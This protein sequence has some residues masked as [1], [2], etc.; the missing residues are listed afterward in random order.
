MGR[1]VKN[2]PMTRNATSAES[3]LLP[4]GPTSGRP[5][6]TDIGQM[7]FNVTDVALEYWDDVAWRTLPHTGLVSI[8]REQ[9]AGDAIE[10]DFTMSLTVALAT[11]ILVFVGGVFQN[12]T[13]SFTVNGTD[14]LVFTSPPPLSEVIVVMHGY[15]EIV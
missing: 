2:P 15:N 14:Q 11:D 4:G 10:T 13:V 6:V 7:R 1:L 9:F 12:P 3:A 5:D 8:T